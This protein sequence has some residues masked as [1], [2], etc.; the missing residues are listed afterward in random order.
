MFK[1][2]KRRGPL[3]ENYDTYIQRSNHSQQ[4]RIYLA[5]PHMSEEGYEIAWIQ[6]A[7]QTN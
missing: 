3:K 5:S 1:V 2:T 7:F 6:E 4:K